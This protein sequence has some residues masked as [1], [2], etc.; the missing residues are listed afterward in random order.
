MPDTP[1]TELLA[2]AMGEAHTQAQQE[3]LGPEE[4]KRLME[5]EGALEGLRH[6]TGMDYRGDLAARRELAHRVAPQEALEKR[7]LLRE[8]EV[9]D[10]TGTGSRKALDRALPRAE[11]RPDTAVIVF[12]ANN[13][14]PINKTLGHAEGDKVL[15][16]LATAILVAA[17][18]YGVGERVFR[19]GGDEFVVLA[20]KDRAAEIIAK[21]EADFSERRYGDTV[22]SLTGTSGD[23]FKVA[24][25]ILQDAK[26]QRKEKH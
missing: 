15:K 26:A 11:L 18:S 3:R 9:D 20:P 12:D 6:D 5:V 21:A 23:T 8:V 4:T 1:R 16:E 10:L 2:G 19:R 14:G 24:D 7:A 13:F 25:A 22:V 17:D